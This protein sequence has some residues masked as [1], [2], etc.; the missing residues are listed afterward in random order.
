MPM[1]PDNL[2]ERLGDLLARIDGPREGLRK[3]AAEIGAQWRG[4]GRV[5]GQRADHAASLLGNLR[6]HLQQIAQAAILC[7]SQIAG[8]LSD[9]FGRSGKGGAHA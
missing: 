4:L 5:G 1:R 9:P 3:E 6:I 7:D 2:I 8:M